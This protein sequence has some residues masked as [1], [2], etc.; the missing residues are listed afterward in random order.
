ML[1]WNVNG[2]NMFAGSTFKNFER[3]IVTVNGFTVLK[4]EPGTGG[5]GDGLYQSD[6]QDPAQVGCDC[7]RRH[8]PVQPGRCL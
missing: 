8:D 7:R 4:S 5:G 1:G 2:A 6:I 3:A